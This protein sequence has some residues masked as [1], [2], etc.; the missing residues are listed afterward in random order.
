[1]C[2]FFKTKTL[3]H[4]RVKIFTPGCVI[5][6]DRSTAQERGLCAC[7]V[8]VFCV[9]LM[10]WSAAENS[11]E[12]FSKEDDEENSFEREERHQISENV[13]DMDMDTN[14]LNNTLQKSSRTEITTRLHKLF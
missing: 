1:M 5:I 4:E 3:A 6:I 11:E 14:A 10:S 7:V 13:D 8:F 12:N 2:V 9:G